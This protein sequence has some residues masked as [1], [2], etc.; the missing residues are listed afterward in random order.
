MAGDMKIGHLADATTG[1]VLAA[2]AGGAAGLLATDTLVELSANRIAVS[3]F[4]AQTN[5]P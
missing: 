5:P 3:Q 4:N 1:S 2:S